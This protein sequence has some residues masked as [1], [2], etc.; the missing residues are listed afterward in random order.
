M[1]QEIASSLDA[2]VNEVRKSKKYSVVS[3]ELVRD[4]LKSE[5]GKGKN[6]KELIKSIRNKIHQVGS[7]FQEEMI[8]YSTWITELNT[9]STD[10]NSK[11]SIAFIHKWLQ[12]HSSTRERV[13]F[14]D[15]FFQE[16][17]APIQPVESIL[18][19]ACGFTP[20]CIPWMPL[21]SGFSYTGIDIYQDM[22]GF[23]DQFFDHLKIKHSFSVGNILESLQ[24]EKTHVA[25]LLKTIPCL[26]QVDKSIGSRLLEN[27]PSDNILVS[28]PSRSL[29]GR[30]KG[31]AVNYEAHFMQLIS[32]KNWKITNTEFPNEIVFLVQ[33]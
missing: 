29:S 25:F 22:I 12:F 1:K 15:R 26:E 14:I 23:L 24:M 17:L 3:E 5:L 13:P 18:D 9:L 31:M 6:Q 8:P 11:Q 16:S 27:I 20:L 33:K 4:I 2:L 19:L 21:A 30:S 28:F 10:L 32:G 7:S